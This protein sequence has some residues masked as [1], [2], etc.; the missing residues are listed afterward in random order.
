MKKWSEIVY[1]AV[2]LYCVILTGVFLILSTLLY[3]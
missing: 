1:G 2:E 3:Q